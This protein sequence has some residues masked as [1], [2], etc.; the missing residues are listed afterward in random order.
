MVREEHGSHDNREQLVETSGIG[1]KILLSGAVI[2]YRHCVSYR[3][4]IWWQ[5]TADYTIA[6][7]PFHPRG[8]AECL[9]PRHLYMLT[10]VHVHD[11][12]A[13]LLYS[14]FAIYI[15]VQ[16]YQLCTC[17]CKFQQHVAPKKKSLVRSNVCR[18]VLTVCQSVVVRVM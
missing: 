17:M 13:Q 15:I 5:N 12:Y 10:V 9:V 16:T 8:A 18:K 6:S 3:V 14:V 7:M 11:M 2:F 1:R 4:G